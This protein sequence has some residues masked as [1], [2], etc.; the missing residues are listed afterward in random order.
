[1]MK[2]NNTLF[3]DISYLL[4]VFWGTLRELDLGIED[5]RY[6]AYVSILFAAISIF[7]RFS[8]SLL[9]VLLLIITTG[10]AFFIKTYHLDISLLP[11]S[12]LVFAAN[13]ISLSHIFKISLTTT[14]VLTSVVV[15]LSLMGVLSDI[16]VSRSVEDQDFDAHCLGFKYYSFPAFRF[17]FIVF[18][19][20]YF[21]KDSPHFLKVSGILV[22]IFLA[23]LITSKRLFLLATLSFLFLFVTVYKFNILKF[24]SRKWKYMSFVLFPSMLVLSIVLPIA[25]FVSPLLIDWINE[26]T[27]GRMALMIQAFYE[28]PVNL[29]GNNIDMVGAV[30]AEYSS[31]QYF[32]IDSGY[33]YWLLV[34][35][36]I[37]T[38]LI[39]L[40][41]TTLFYRAY[42]NNNRYVYIYCI[43]VAF[44]NLSNDF[45]SIS[46]VNPL[47]FLIFADISEKS[48]I[49]ID[50]NV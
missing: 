6:I 34:Y 45:F 42:I 36:V 30:E 11:I 5:P 13:G 18:L 40:A 2:N 20:L 17:I 8:F 35:G 48:L 4:Y 39:L 16:I 14:I 29:W 33:V 23:Y 3:F 28:Y 12:F 49:K 7:Q 9:H 24:I 31:L 27:S 38:C 32:Y 19:S 1:M 25:T 21:M 37:V 10:L 50:K 15:C 22:F 46:Y 47:I 43:L 44:I 26:N 41:Y